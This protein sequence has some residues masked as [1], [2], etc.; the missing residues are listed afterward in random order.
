MNDESQVVKLNGSMSELQLMWKIKNLKNG[1]R[2]VCDNLTVDI[3]SSRGEL[4]NP[5][6][7]KNE[8][9]QKE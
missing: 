4:L 6:D 1:Q 8:M 2:I 5:D 7:Y 3:F 9:A